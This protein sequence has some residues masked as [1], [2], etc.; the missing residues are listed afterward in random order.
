MG[1]SDPVALPV[2]RWDAERAPAEARAW[3]R[4]VLQA[5]ETHGSVL[6]SME[7]RD[8]AAW[9]PAYSGASRED[10]RAFWAGLFSAL[11]KHESTWNPEAVG[12]GGRWFGL[13][14]ISPA[15]ARNY[16]CEASSGE[17]LKNGAANL[18]CA[19]RIASHTVARDGVVA[20]DGRGIAADWAPFHDSAKRRDMADWVST[21]SY[22][23][24]G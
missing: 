1:G 20:A 7:P 6:P 2:M 3:S 13:L 22:C 4:A 8:I 12:G 18:S 17:A 10:R 16:G 9:C 15:T 19:V 23:R 21:Q 24:K 14:Q 5:L 11:A